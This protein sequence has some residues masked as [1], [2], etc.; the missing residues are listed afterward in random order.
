MNTETKQNLYMATAVGAALLAGGALFHCGL[1]KEGTRQ[2]MQYAKHFETMNE[3]YHA[4]KMEK[5]KE[6]VRASISKI[7]KDLE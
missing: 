2:K 6:A 5:T 4:E 3:I 1:Q 7:E